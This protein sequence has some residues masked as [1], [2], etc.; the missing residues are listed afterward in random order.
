MERKN[1]SM[2]LKENLLIRYY[3]LRDFVS[4]SKS[5]KLKFLSDIIGFSEVTKTKEVLKK[6]FKSIKTEIK[7]QNFEALIGVQKETLISKIGAVASQEDKF[8]DKIN[9]IVPPL[10]INIVAK[11]IQDIDAIL[12]QINNPQN[13]KQINLKSFLR[14]QIILLPRLKTK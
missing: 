2:L 9:E 1:I 4:Q 5:D 6:T 13:E 8:I 11:N 12:K 7:A 10:K 3:L 14:W